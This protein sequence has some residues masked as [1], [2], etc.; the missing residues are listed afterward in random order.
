MRTAAITRKTGETDIRLTLG[1]PENG[2]RGSFTGTSGVGFFDHMLNS[3]AVHG[4][5]DI[6][7]DCKGDL[8]VDCHHTVEDIGIVLGKA[9]AAAAGDCK[10]IAR[11]AD[12]LLPMDEA[13]CRCALDFSGRPF[14]VFDAS[15]SA[16]SIGAYDT[17]MTAEFMRALAFNAGI[18]L[19]LAVLYGENDHH[20]TE[21][22]YKACA[23][24]LGAALRVVSAEI[25][26][27]KGT[28]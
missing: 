7:L 19:H 5:F 2:G 8:D 20:K 15:F 25:P 23:K 12:I 9:F 13:L 11:F 24:C 27:T 26:S 22:L 17:Q 1:I 28:L 6:T 14:L 3:F 16:Q 18:T 10:G 4:G 21:A